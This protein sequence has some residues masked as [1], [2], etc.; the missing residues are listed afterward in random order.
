MVES[1]LSVTF[2]TPTTLATRYLRTMSTAGGCSGEKI[3][4][5]QSSPRRS[6]VC[7]H[8]HRRGSL[9]TS[10]DQWNSSTAYCDPR[11]RVPT[12]RMPLNETVLTNA[13]GV[14]QR[15]IPKC[16]V[17]FPHATGARRRA[18]HRRQNDLHG[19]RD[20][21]NQRV[22]WR[23]AAHVRLVADHEGRLVRS[24]AE[25]VG[26]AAFDGQAVARPVARKLS[27]EVGLWIWA[28]SSPAPTEPARRKGQK[29]GNVLRSEVRGGRKSWISKGFGSSGGLETETPGYSRCSAVE[30]WETSV[31]RQRAERTL[32][33]ADAPCGHA[34]DETTGEP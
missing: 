26:H 16:Q 15:R 10:M 29:T 28:R 13:S 9:S 18:G 19:P 20:C 3:E 32:I 23:P 7:A 12:E 5:P 8:G 14:V 31:V 30:L 34:A 21:R 17:R 6:S 25:L 11:T 1:C 24:V 33:V 4:T 2:S 22:T 27:A